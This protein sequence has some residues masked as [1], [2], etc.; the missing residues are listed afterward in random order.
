MFTAEE[1]T[2]FGL[3]CLGSR[4]MAGALSLERAAALRGS[5]GRSLEEL[6]RMAGCTGELESVALPAGFYHSF[7]ELH[8]EQ[9]PILEREGIPIGLVE[10]IAGPSSYR[11]TLTGEG[12][13]AGAVLMPDRHDAS[14]AAA[15]VA[16]AV[17]RSGAE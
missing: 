13:H 11:L 4:L 10:H 17:E 14:L 16:L 3:G 12:G 6:R 1:P 2:R 8:I 9:G 5:G 7:V 15:E